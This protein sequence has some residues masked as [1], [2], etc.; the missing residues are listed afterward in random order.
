MKTE[1]LTYDAYNDLVVGEGSDCVVVVPDYHGFT[2]YARRTAEG[3]AGDTRRGVLLD[4]YGDRAMPRTGN[5]AFE[6][7]SPMLNDRS[8]ALTRLTACVDRLH[9]QGVTRIVMV[10]YSSGGAFVLDAARTGL[11]IQGVA[12]IWGLLEPMVPIPQV[13]HPVPEHT[14]PVLVVQGGKDELAPSD[15]YAS[16]A[17]ELDTLGLD[18]Q[19][20]IIG[21]AKHAFTLREE[22]NV[23][24][25]SGEHPALLL[26]DA[27]AERRSDRLLAGFLEEVFA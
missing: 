9:E 14:M 15:R 23:E 21:T 16:L 20:H 6:Q 27:E 24:V 3:F 1:D 18:W 5:E 22:D 4:L 2:P 7:V 12:S 10:G 25:Q 26:Y 13:M 11:G 8:L 19:L 17:I